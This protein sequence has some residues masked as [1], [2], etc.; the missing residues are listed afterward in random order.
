MTAPAFAAA[1]K[2]FL[3]LGLLRQQQRRATLQKTR[4]CRGNIDRRDALLAFKL[5]NEFSENSTLTRR[6]RF[7]DAL[8]EP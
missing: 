7:G 3:P 8:L 1:L 2:P 4:E 5:L 6:H